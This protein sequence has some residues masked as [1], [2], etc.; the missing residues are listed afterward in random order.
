MPSIV[1][2]PR[3]AVESNVPTILTKWICTISFL[4]GY[5]LADFR[6]EFHDLRS[7]DPRAQEEYAECLWPTSYSAWQGLASQLLELGSAGIVYPCVRQVGGTCVA[8]FR[9]VLVTNV[10]LGLPYFFSMDGK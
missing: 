4:E 6:A 3:K 2:S 9:P 7:T 5:Y 10:R 8:C 1:S